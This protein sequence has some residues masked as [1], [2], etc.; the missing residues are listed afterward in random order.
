MQRNQKK[1]LKKGRGA[2]GTRLTSLDAELE[3]RVLVA[4]H[5]CPRV[6]LERARGPLPENK[7]VG[8]VD[9]PDQKNQPG[10]R[11]Q[12]RTKWL[13]PF[14]M[15]C[16]SAI[17]FLLPVTTRITSRASMTVAIPTVRAMRGTAERS[18]LKKRALARMVS[19]ARVLM[20]VRET[21]EEPGCAEDV[22]SAG[23]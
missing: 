2:K 8:L 19:Y 1:K 10:G 14:S 22:G 5:Q 21:R 13:T 17:A 18:L 11:A 23:F 7:R 12:K 3:G 20:R 6:A 15:H 9:S 16:D 4:H